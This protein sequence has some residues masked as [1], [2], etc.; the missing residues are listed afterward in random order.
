MKRLNAGT[1]LLRLAAHFV[2]RSKS[3]ES[4]KRSVFNALRHDWSGA[5]LELQNK[6][7]MSSVRLVVEIFRETEQEQI[8]ALE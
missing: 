5:L 3:I 6:M 4:I 1:E 8:A 2:Q 7:D